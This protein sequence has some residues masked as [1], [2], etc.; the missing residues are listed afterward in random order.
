MA[1]I[2]ATLSSTLARDVYPIA[3]A[4]SPI[5]AKALLA[6]I[7]RNDI[8]LLE[9]SL[10]KGKTGGPAGIKISTGFGCVLLGKSNK[11]KGQTF[12]VFSRHQIISR[13]A[14]QF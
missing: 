12:I 6:R 9:N 10:F 5:V 1:R 3:R 13:L 11:T 7:Y 4:S 8:S 14:K 2:T